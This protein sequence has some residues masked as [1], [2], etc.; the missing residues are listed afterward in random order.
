MTGPEG[1]GKTGLPPKTREFAVKIE[2][3]ETWF[4]FG[5]CQW[6]N[7][8]RRSARTAYPQSA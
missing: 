2:D 4:S 8:S 7:I 3:R 5:L 6:P 1:G